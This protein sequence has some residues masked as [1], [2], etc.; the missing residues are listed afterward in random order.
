MEK[1]F[2]VRG[3]N[4]TIHMPKELDHHH[5]EEIKKEADHLLETRNIRSI[6]FDFEKTSFMD[7]SG[8]GLIL[9]RYRWMQ[10]LGGSVRITHISSGLE[11]LLVLSGIHKL[12]QV[13]SEQSSKEEP[14][15]E[16]AEEREIFSDSSKA[17][18]FQGK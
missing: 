16:S 15:K 9:G 8:I 12:V 5:A 13:E 11:Q 10:D 3:T 14:Q 18:R 6:I 1:T 17:L 7:S 2:V 4:L